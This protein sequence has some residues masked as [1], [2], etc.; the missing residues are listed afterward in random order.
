MG[1]GGSCRDTGSVRDLRFSV[2]KFAVELAGLSLL[3][4]LHGLLIGLDHFGRAAVYGGC[5]SFSD[6]HCVVHR[7]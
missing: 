6:P 4:W 1:V 7:I 2:N 5:G 3:V